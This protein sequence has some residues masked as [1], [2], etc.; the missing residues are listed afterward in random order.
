M[1]KLAIALMALMGFV[2]MASCSNDETYA[3]QRERE[4]AAIAKFISDSAVT[5][6][7]EEQFFK[8]DSTTD[9][10]KNEY[11]L[12]ESSGVYLQIIDKGCGEK[13]KNGE[14][15]TVLCRFTERNILT[16]SLTLT[17]NSLYFSAIVDK[18]YVSNSYGTYQGAFDTSSSVMYQVYGKSSSSTA[19]PSGWLTPFPYIKVGR[20]EKASDR[21][22]HV[23]MIVPSTKGTLNASTNV[24]P[25]LYDIT[26]ERGR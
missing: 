2:F 25:C 18:M 6:I 13:I 9:V 21:L 19:V 7:S 15:T 16:D 8:Q 1:K 26:Y 3:E 10:S 23:K 12:L 22:A 20:K 24:Y 11:V 5:V 4:N 17:N 14:T